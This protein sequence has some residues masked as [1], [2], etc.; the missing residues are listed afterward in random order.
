MGE[1][2]PRVGGTEGV[3][4]NGQT[5][6]LDWSGTREPLQYVGLE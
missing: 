4:V 6:N 1:D 5:V 2:D 3:G